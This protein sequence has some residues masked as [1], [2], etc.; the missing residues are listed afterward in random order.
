MAFHSIGSLPIAVIKQ[1]REDVEMQVEKELLS[2]AQR[3][4]ALFCPP[5][6]SPQSSMTASM[7]ELPTISEVA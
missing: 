6:I 1:S 5:R 4:E 3:L 7:K 2:H